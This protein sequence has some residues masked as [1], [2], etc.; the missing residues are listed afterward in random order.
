M[1]DQVNY[2]I[3]VTVSPDILETTY[4]TTDTEQFVDDWG[5]HACYDLVFTIDTQNSSTALGAMNSCPQQT[6]RTA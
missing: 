3:T 1:G 6:S 4:T 2:E 5:P